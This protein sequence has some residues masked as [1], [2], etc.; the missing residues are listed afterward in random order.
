MDKQSEGGLMGF[1]GDIISGGASGI[2]DSVSTA[3]DKFV[4]TDKEREELK[5]ELI[6]IQN[7]ALQK[8]RES[9]LKAEEEMSKR[10]E[11][12]NATIRAEAAAEHWPTYAWRPF[13]GFIFGLYVASLFILPIFGIAPVPLSPDI[14]LTIGAILGVASF[15]RGKAQADPNIPTINRG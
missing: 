13:I 11:S 3:V 9:E 2:I 1:L 10:I 7:E 5:I 8:A 6:K 4:T 12:V 15:F 14:T